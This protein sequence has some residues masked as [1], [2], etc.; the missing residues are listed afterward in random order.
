[1]RHKLSFCF[2][3]LLILSATFSAPAQ[4]ILPRLQDDDYYGHFYKNINNYHD[5]LCKSL[6][7]YYTLFVKFRL[8]EDGAVDSIRFSI[9]R[10]AIVLEAITETLKGMT[11]LV[12]NRF[13]KNTWYVQPLELNFFREGKSQYI[14]G[15]FYQCLELPK[16]DTTDWQAGL[17]FNQNGF[18]E[19]DRKEQLGIQCVFLKPVILQ[20][21]K[22]FHHSQGYQ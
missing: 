14:D 12:R 7:S 20:R 2:F 11:L 13:L 4:K 17:N 19:V 21:T 16:I 1:M 10:P 5:T 6:D 18:F 3:V 8:N 15:K 9:K 22:V